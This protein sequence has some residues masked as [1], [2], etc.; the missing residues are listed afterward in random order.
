MVVIARGL[1][2]SIWAWPWQF[3]PSFLR[4]IQF[5]WRLCLFI[6]LASSFLAALAFYLLPLSRRWL[7]IVLAVLIILLTTSA[8]FT[9]EHHQEELK[10]ID[11]TTA[12]AVG[13]LGVDQE[14]LPLLTKDHREELAE[15]PTGVLALP[16]TL[17]TTK[18]TTP[19]SASTS[20]LPL[21]ATPSAQIIA[22]DPPYLEFTISSN[23]G[24]T[25]NFELPRLYYLGYQIEFWPATAPSQSTN[26]HYNLAYLENDRGLMAI[27]VVGNG[28][29]VVTYP[30]TLGYRLG[31]WL[32]G[33]TLVVILA[34]GIKQKRKH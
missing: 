18:S 10:H 7:N 29:V 5:P 8:Y 9:S 22:D 4:F 6:T 25:T 2:F 17:L 16:S 21:P 27:T 32:A 24:H 14:Y 15:R 28:R 12:A 20:A 33:G 26:L 11:V 34:V 1:L 3:A 13:A 30:G 19:H 23:D 31:L